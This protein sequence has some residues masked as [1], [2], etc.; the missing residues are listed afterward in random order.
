MQKKISVI[1]PIYNVE[2]YLRQCL[3]SIINQTYTDLEIILVNDCSTDGSYKICL[4]YAEN[5]RRIKVVNK[6]V[7]GG[8]GSARVTGIS[9]STGDVIAWVDGDDWID[10]NMFYDMMEI[11]CKNNSDIVQCKYYYAYNDKI[12]KTLDS[13]N[14]MILNTV[15]ALKSLLENSHIDTVFW[16]KLYSKELFDDI[17]MSSRRL[18]EDSDTL[19][20]IIFKS[21]VTIFYDKSYY[22]YRQHSESL[23]SGMLSAENAHIRITVEK[24]KLNFI[25]NNIDELQDLCKYKLLTRYLSIY[26]SLKNEGIESQKLLEMIK[27]ESPL[28]YSQ[29]KSTIDLR[30]RIILFILLL[31]IKRG[32]FSKFLN[33]IIKRTYEKKGYRYG[34]IK[35]RWHEVKRT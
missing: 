12:F 24:N 33:R 32:I 9:E 23:V 15:D 17:E 14:I 4:E 29:I 27:Y 5:D 1:V 31:S 13:N 26:Y 25:K 19:Y 10:P 6:E 34:A 35:Y 20:K 22:Y 7:N 8:L 21:K 18:G 28:L 2:K 16:N 30:K 3:D 11:K